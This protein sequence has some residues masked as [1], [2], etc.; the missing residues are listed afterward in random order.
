[1][2]RLVRLVAAVIAA[3]RGIAGSVT[4]QDAADIPDP[5]VTPGA[6]VSTDRTMACAQGRTT[7]P[8]MVDAECRVLALYG[9]QWSERGNYEIDH[10]VPRCIGGADTV[11]NLWPEPLAE[12]VRKD[13]KEREICRAVCDLGSMLITEGQRFFIDR[14]WR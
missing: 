10:L 6:V 3:A 7:R 8:R 14:R 9:L 13:Q 11:S 12:A 1:V 2:K 5:H 4:A